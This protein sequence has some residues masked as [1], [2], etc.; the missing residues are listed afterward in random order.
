MEAL[1][2]FAIILLSIFAF[3]ILIMLIT[4]KKPLGKILVS[5]AVGPVI[6]LIIKLTAVFTGISIP[7]NYFTLIG[8][9]V[10][11]IP[12]IISFLILKIIFI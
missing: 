8:S 4:D 1:K 9:L 5:I 12:A 3:I 6:L 7:I 2:I 11:G 10:F